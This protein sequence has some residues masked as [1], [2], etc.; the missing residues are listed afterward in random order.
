MIIWE[1]RIGRAAAIGLEMG[2]ERQLYRMDW[3]ELDE[4]H[5]K[6]SEFGIK[7]YELA[8]WAWR[9]NKDFHHH[10]LRWD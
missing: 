2:R 3:G 9:N 6:N 1:K 8:A 7:G 10:V 4:D 5:A